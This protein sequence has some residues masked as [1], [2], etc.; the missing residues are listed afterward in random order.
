MAAIT[1]Q[2]IKQAIMGK[3]IS[4]YNGFN[5]TNDYFKIGYMVK[6]GTSV[7]VFQSKGKGLGVLIPIAAITKL[8]ETG[9]YE[10]RGDIEECSFTTTYK[11]F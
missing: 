7:W 9:K 2:Y 1:M 6:S 11:L 10:T 3:N 5:G 8:V 4:Y